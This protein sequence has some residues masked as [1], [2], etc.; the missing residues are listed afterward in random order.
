[1]NP[2]ST[3]AHIAALSLLDRAFIATPDDE[4]KTLLVTLPADHISAVKR[5]AGVHPGEGFD[6]ITGVEPDAADPD[7]ADAAADDVAAA[8]DAVA[9]ASATAPVDADV[10]QVGDEIV[11]AIRVAARKG[12]LNGDLQRLGVVLSDACL[13]ECVTQLG[14]KADLP[15]KDDLV[16][17][18]PGLVERHGKG[19]VQIML[20][21]TVVG[22]APASVT[23][24]EMLKSDELVK[25]PPV[26]PKPIAPLL[27]LKEN[28]AERESLRA[29]R[30]ERKA[31]EQAAA[32]ARRD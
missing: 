9:A 14:D 29:A 28:D 10:S 22:E 16:A 8:D 30:K 32:K 4:I 21:S 1:M 6:H 27:P 3:K 18:M 19:V 17:V 25:L 31:A 2:N 24:I 7:E 20:A 13:A 15:S 12:R 26:D 23:I 5:I 11:G